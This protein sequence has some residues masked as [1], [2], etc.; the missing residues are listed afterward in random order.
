MR[1]WATMTRAVITRRRLA[2]LVVGVVVSLSSATVVLAAGLLVASDAP[3]D[4]AFTR[5]AG[6]HV[7][8]VFDPGRASAAELAA[9][10]HR[11][12]V[13]AVAGPFDAVAV[14]L[15]AGE[16]KLG[17]ARVVGRSDQGGPV[18]RIVLDAGSWLTGPG[19]IVLAR[20]LAG[21]P[22][23][24]EY[25]S[26][27]PGIPGS[28]KLRVVG[29]ADSITDTADAWVWPTE[30][31]VL[32][33]PGAMTSRRMLY[34]FAAAGDE[35]AVHGSLAAAT[36]ALPGDAV[37]GVS[38]YLTGKMAVDRT[39]RTVLPFVVAF[40]A[41]GLVVSVLIVANVVSGAVV[42]GYRSI[43]VL[44]A[45]GYTPGQVVAVYAGQVLGSAGPG[46]VVAGSR[47]L[48]VTGRAVG[49]TLTVTGELGARQVRVVGETF[50][51]THDGLALI[52]DLATLSQL[53]TQTTPD[54]FDI[55]LS[56]ATAP[57]PYLRSLNDAL[58]PHRA[59][60]ERRR[61]QDTAIILMHSLITTLT[62]LLSAVAILGVFNTVVLNTRER[63]H[64][65]GV[66][67]SI[68]MTPRQIQTMVITSMAGIGLL[69]GFLATP[70]GY[71][72]HHA[73]IPLMAQAAGTRIPVSL[74][75]VYAPAQLAALAGTGILLALLGALIP[76]SCSARTR[77]STALRAE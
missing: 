35:A 76:A 55:A 18:D 8:A 61:D 64:S 70:L 33:A 28:P 27:T 7:S 4:R 9:T 73:I 13:T 20:D 19:Q 26:V 29:I 52:G 49:D 39:T 43:G 10:A 5:Q 22:R 17:T 72:F 60:A 47:L 74:L 69:A 21:G 38:T 58:A 68:G 24:M 31:G 41:L 65:I 37:I 51:N 48:D 71:R 77:V 75:E 40:A 3:F 14:E 42:A 57:G 59:I 23:G 12:G 44:K 16:I 45:L 2:S 25:G 63:L 1:A 46:E 62:I 11:P 67:K 66:L 15:A 53:S 36:A 30:D 32:H 34:R 50:D 6:A 54:R 56:Q